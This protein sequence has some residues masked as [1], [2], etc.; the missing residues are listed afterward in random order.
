MLTPSPGEGK[1]WTR[2]GRRGGTMSFSESVTEWRDA[3]GELV[4]TARSVGVQTG[5]VPTAT[6][7]GA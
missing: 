1:T 4:V 5:K 2:E 3:D 7:A 6:E